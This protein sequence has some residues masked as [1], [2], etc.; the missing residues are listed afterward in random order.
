MT[1]TSLRPPAAVFPLALV[2]VA[3]VGGGSAC[4]SPSGVPLEDTPQELA[5]ALCNQ[6]VHC[7][8]ARTIGGS[9]SYL[10]LNP[11]FEEVCPQ[12]FAREFGSVDHL[13]A[14]VA[15]GT[16]AYDPQAGRRCITE[17]TESCTIEGG[18]LFFPSCREAFRGLVP[19]GETCTVSE[20]CVPGS[21][22]DAELLVDT[23]TPGECVAL[24]PLGATCDDSDDCVPPE[25]AGVTIC[26]NNGGA[27]DVCVALTMTLGAVEDE[28]CGSID[29]DGVERGYGVCA[30]D[31]FCDDP[32]E[33]GVG[34]C[35]PPVATGAVCT[36]GQA[37]EF[38]SVCVPADMQHECVAVTL[39]TTVGGACDDET[40]ICDFTA[41]LLC[42][43]GQCQPLPA[44]ACGGAIF[45]EVDEYCD[46]D[47][48]TCETRNPNGTICDSSNE[49]ISDRCADDGSMTNTRRCTDRVACG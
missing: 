39:V 8:T 7:A 41:R 31:F 3:L 29:E 30:A 20:E 42:E 44:G 34:T 14:A 17:I 15:A 48:D 11:A 18:F 19:V 49:C 9:L 12:Q 33:D 24:L 37:C 28:P 6:L 5:G 26:R 4:S 43:A 23:C 25:G 2:V 32:D 40:S 35:Q 1:S 27:D 38:G 47:T 36:P 13:E 21:R 10:A 16:L 22:C 46:G 45:C